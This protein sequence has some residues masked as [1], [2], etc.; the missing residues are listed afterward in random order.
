[1][2]GRQ[3]WQWRKWLQWG[4]DPEHCIKR[5]QFDICRKRICQFDFKN[6]DNDIQYIE[7]TS[8]KNSGTITATVEVLKER[9]TFAAS[10]PKGV[11]YR[12]INIWLGKTGYVTETNLESPVIGFKVD[13]SWIEDEGIDPAS[14]VLNRYSGDKWNVLSTTQT[15][16][17]DKYYYYQAETPGFSPFAITGVSLDEAALHSTDAG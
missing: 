8:L 7:Y 9:S 5:C 15:K 17:D 11:I 13:K 16:S 10:S 1:M 4:E 14:V 12:H 6:S 2:E 3:W